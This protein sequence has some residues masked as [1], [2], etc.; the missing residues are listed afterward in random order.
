MIKGTFMTSMP[1]DNSHV[2]MSWENWKDK[3]LQ[4][5]RGTNQ[6]IFLLPHIQKNLTTINREKRKNKYVQ[7][8]H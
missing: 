4:F 2:R 6:Y 5:L 1:G 3:P 7:T 8:G